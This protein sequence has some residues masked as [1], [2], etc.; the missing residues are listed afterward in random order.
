M[1]HLL[2]HLVGLAY[3]LLSCLE[4]TLMTFSYEVPQESHSVIDR[5]G[6]T[7]GSCTWLEQGLLRSELITAL[8]RALVLFFKG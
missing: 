6:V 5:F 2:A 3:E 4:F 7:S 1:H 8:Q